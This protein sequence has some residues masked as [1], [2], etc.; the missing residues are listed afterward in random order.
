MTCGP[1]KIDIM[2]TKQT[3]NFYLINQLTKFD[4]YTKFGSRRIFELNS[5]NT[6]LVKIL[7]FE[8]TLFLKRSR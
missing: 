4:E 3:L 1:T 6:T 2:L 5:T 8:V 7:E